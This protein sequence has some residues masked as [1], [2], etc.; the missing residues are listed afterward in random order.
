MKESSRRQ[1]Q[2]DDYDYDESVRVKQQRIGSETSN[3]LNL[4][5]SN[6]EPPA[7]IDQKDLMPNETIRSKAN[8]K[9]LPGLD[10]YMSTNT[11]EDNISFEVLMAES[12]KKERAKMHNAWLR[13]RELLQKIVRD[14]IF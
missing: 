5:Y 3:R 14:L 11:S 9:D 2:S 1:Q 6:D 12:E 13:E 4:P 10:S 8:L 7:N